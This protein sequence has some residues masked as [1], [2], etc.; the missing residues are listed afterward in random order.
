MLC[1][2]RGLLQP[3][4]LLNQ[5]SVQVKNYDKAEKANALEVCISN[6]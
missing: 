2:A 1:A 3:F 6:D 4:V 5:L